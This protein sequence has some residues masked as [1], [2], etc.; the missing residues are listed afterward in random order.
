MN[1]FCTFGK[2]DQDTLLDRQACFYRAVFSPKD[3]VPEVYGSTNPD[4]TLLFAGVPSW[5]PHK[6]YTKYFFST[7]EY[8]SMRS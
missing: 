6:I 7:A 4:S 2:E 8:A 1:A 3:E 5:Q